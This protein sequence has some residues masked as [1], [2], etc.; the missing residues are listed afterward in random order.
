MKRYLLILLLLSL[1][2]CGFQFA[3]SGSVLPENIKNVYI[4]DVTNDTTEGAIG[5]ILSEALRDR[6]ERY[7][8]LVVVESENQADAVLEV[9]LKE[10]K[11]DTRS[12]TS[13]TDTAL[14]LDTVMKIA[15]ELR[16]VTGQLL[17]VDSDITVSSSF[18]TSQ[19]AIVTSSAQFAASGLNKNDINNLDSRE[20]SR[21]QE[22]LVLEKLC[23]Q[24]AKR[25]YDSAVLPEF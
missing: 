6:F 15:G 14:Q 24:T 13:N 17:W 23:E 2:A 11:R 19:E 9:T 4:P 16:S 5:L 21:G 1:T 12:V 20:L 10:I 25:I 7:G 8:T 3:G 22:Q 18:G